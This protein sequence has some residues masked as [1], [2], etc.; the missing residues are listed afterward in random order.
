LAGRGYPTADERVAFLAAAAKA[1]RPVRTLR[2]VLHA[3]GR[4]VAEVLALAPEPVD[5]AGR[6]AVSETLEKRRQG[7][8][9]AVPV[10][11]GPPHQ[12]GLVRG[13]REAQ[14]RGNGHADRPLR[15]W[16]RM[17]ARRQATRASWLRTPKG[18]AAGDYARQNGL[19]PSRQASA[20][21]RPMS[22]S[23]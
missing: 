20:E 7:V 16:S 10:P 3:T 19:R 12:L 9:R 13:L 17:T 8:C 14:R 23:A 6:A 1:A 2:G 22:L 5:P 18:P 21:L 11:A 15:P 4:R